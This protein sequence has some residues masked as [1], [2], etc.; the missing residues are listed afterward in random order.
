MFL[1]QGIDAPLRHY[2]QTNS[3]CQYSVTILVTSDI[4]LLEIIIEIVFMLD[5]TTIVVASSATFETF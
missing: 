2:R 1:G 4:I 5:S 3:N